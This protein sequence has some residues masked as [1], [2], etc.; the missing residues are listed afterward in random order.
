MSSSNVDDKQKV[1]QLKKEIQT[2]SQKIIQ[3]NND[4]KD[5][6][7]GFI[8]I[9]KAIKALNQLK[10]LNFKKKKPLISS[11]FDN[12]DVPDEFICPISKEIMNDP[13]ILASGQTYD[14]PFIQKWITEVHNTCPQ[15][16]QVLTHTVL[17]P[18]HLIREL[19]Q[20]WCKDHGIQLPL[21]VTH[22]TEQI[23]IV[24]DPD[25]DRLNVTEQIEIVP[26]PDRDR[27]NELLD[28]LSST[29]PDQKQAAK[30][31]R[32]F[33]KST[34]SA[35]SSFID[36]TDG[37]QKLISPILPLGKLDNHLD[38]QEDLVTCVLNVSIPEG[39]KK[40][41]AEHPLV[42]PLLVESL[43]RGTLETRCNA[44]AALFTL[45]ALESNK[46]LIGDAYALTPLIDLLK[47]DN[48]SA[49]ADAANAIFNL[50]KLPKNRGRA[51]NGGAVR[52][53]LR[54]IKDGFLVGTMLS[55]L[56]L[57]ATHESGTAQLV[58]P[59][60][61]A[62]KCLLSIIKES[63]KERDK[64]NCIDI[65]YSMCR[66]NRDVLREVE[67]EEKARLTISKLADEGSSRAKKIADRLLDK[68]FR[69]AMAGKR[70]YKS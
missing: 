22:V 30:D 36:C 21:P 25:R 34:P 9:N 31:I 42:V 61:R 32:L 3:Q 19:I 16:R 47:E 10:D 5:S 56:A 51:V 60:L 59:E 37:I 46:E 29:L 15:T 39:N 24:P 27:L 63:T 67:H 66:K 62:V 38:L 57:L 69:D 68:F 54:K 65:V 11:N 12:F 40:I 49:M 8:T 45:S 4:S 55:I 13:V 44:A 70:T 17:T 33:T 7:Y 50:C 35:Q 18:N 53:I 64:E 26:N 1:E 6:D 58:D 20:Q 48:L 52:V 41:I 2:L 28:K 23:E 43:K 14:R